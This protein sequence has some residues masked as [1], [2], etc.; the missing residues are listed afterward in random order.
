MAQE[1]PLAFISRTSCKRGIQSSSCFPENKRHFRYRSQTLMFWEGTNRC[2]LLEPIKTNIICRRSFKLLDVI[3]DRTNNYNSATSSQILPVPKSVPHLWL[4]KTRRWNKKFAWTVE[5]LKL[6]IRNPDDSETTEI[7]CLRCETEI[8]N[9]R[10]VFIK[11]LIKTCKWN[12]LQFFSKY[13]QSDCS[14]R[15]LGGFPPALA[16]L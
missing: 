5:G 10:S 14:L 4:L 12:L 16:T 13:L 9:N 2:S 15:L 8:D 3:A 11:A 6:L 7:D 1:L